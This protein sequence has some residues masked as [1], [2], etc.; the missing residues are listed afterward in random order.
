MDLTSLREGKR[1]TVARAISM[2]ENGAD[3]ARDMLR[4]I[5]PHTGG[6]SI[7][8]ITGSAGAGK[9]SL[10]N[11]LAVELSKSGGKPAV[12]AV[13]PTSHITGGAILGDRVRMIESTDSGVYIRSIASRGPPAR[14][15][16]PCATA[17]AYWSTPALIP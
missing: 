1:G 3:G 17:S 4:E 15:R 10:I 5:F 7:I 12:L 6:A 11:S 16:D 13:D 14:C 9:S 2:V 8:G